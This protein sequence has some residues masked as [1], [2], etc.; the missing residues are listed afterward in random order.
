LTN[1][2]CCCNRVNTSARCLHDIALN[3]CAPVCHHQRQARISES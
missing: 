1:N 2:W 3:C